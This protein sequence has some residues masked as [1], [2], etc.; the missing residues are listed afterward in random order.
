VIKL[1]PRLPKREKEIPAWVIKLGLRHSRKKETIA[2]TQ[3]S[4]L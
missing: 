3:E 2:R 1:G 4:P